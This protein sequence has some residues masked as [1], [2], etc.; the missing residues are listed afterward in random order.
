MLPAKYTLETAPQP[1][2][3]DVKIAEL[4]A[5]TVAV[6]TFSGSTSIDTCQPEVE[7][8]LA[9]LDEAKIPYA[10]RV[11]WSLAAYNS[12]FTLPFMRTNEIH[13]PLNGYER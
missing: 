8:L 3:P 11:E 12:P 4:P 1:T 9:D 10:S 2:N 13:V 7:A 5:A 6:R